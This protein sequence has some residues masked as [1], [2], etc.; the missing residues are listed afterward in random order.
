[1]EILSVVTVVTNSAIVV[2]VGTQLR[3][4]NRNVPKNDDDNGFSRWTNVW[5]FLVLEHVILMAK[6]AL[7][8]FIPDQPGEV[9]QHIARQ[10]Y[11]VD[12]LLNNVPDPADM[13][14]W[15]K[16]NMKR[17]KRRKNKETKLHEG[18]VKNDSDDS[19]D[20]RRNS[21]NNYYRRLG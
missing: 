16:R 20:Y 13:T 11:I 4:F 10:E 15:R 5:V 3:D 21:T 6:F 1:M 18:E 9:T 19:E 12:A 7:Q 14:S 8:Y 17:R 2:F